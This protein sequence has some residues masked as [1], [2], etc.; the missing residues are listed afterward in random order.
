MS[1]LSERILSAWNTAFAF[2]RANTP[3]W[4][5]VTVGVIV[6]LWLCFAAISAFNQ[7]NEKSIDIPQRWISALSNLGIIPVYPPSGDIMVGD[8]IATIEPNG[9]F[10]DPILKK[11]ITLA[12]LDM[13]DQLLS[14]GNG[15]PRLTKRRSAK[16]EDVQDLT[17]NLVNPP[18]TSIRMSEV[19]FP[20]GELSLSHTGNGVFSSIG[21]D[22]L[23]SHSTN[24]KVTIGSAYT[25]GIPAADAYAYLNRHCKA[26]E[27]NCSENYVRALMAAVVGGKI[28]D[29]ENSGNTGSEKRGVKYRYN[30]VISIVS[31]IYVSDD[32]SASDVR[33]GNMTATVTVDGKKTGELGGTSTNSVSLAGPGGPVV[34]GFQSMSIRPRAAT[35]GSQVCGGS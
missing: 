6:T 17:L 11:T 31:R 14:D 22:G 30:V 13:S 32:I 27:I 2:F 9:T 26:Y 12:R 25:I 21:L 29:T 19:R 23:F 16:T 1:E 34:F 15:V 28:C 33:G 18:N 24:R 20:A 8:I 5:R 3:A 35:K 7:Q 10:D 4:V